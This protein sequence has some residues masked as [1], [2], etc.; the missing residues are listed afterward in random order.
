[1]DA[2]MEVVSDLSDSQNLYAVDDEAGEEVTSSG[3][4]EFI[5]FC[6]ETPPESP[7][8]NFPAPDAP[9]PA[10]QEA[11]TAEVTVPGLSSQPIGARLASQPSNHQSHAA[12]PIPTTAANA[13]LHAKRQRGASSAGPSHAGSQPGV[14]S[15]GQGPPVNGRHLGGASTSSHGVHSAY[16]EE[17]PVG[18]LLRER[19]LC[20]VLDLDHTL[21]NS[22]KFSEVEPEHLLVRPD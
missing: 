1:M 21:V 18:A 2:D 15:A 20:L 9:H 4:D 16:M 10:G 6:P 17:G 11:T 12:G 13:R 19:R 14:G 3:A 5:P 7:E 8:R 22:A